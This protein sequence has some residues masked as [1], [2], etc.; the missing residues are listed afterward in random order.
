MRFDI[1]TIFPHIFA[2]YFNE[3]ILKR[4]QKKKKIKI[5][6]WDIRK[7]TRDKHHTVDDRPYGGGPGMV[8]KIEPIVHCLKKISAQRRIRLLGGKKLKK[9]KIILFTPRGKQ[10]NQEMLRRWSKLSQLIFVCGHYEGIDERVTKFVDEEISVGPYILTSGELPTMIVVDAIT[11]L[12]PGVLGGEL[13]TEEEIN[14]KK[15]YLAYPQYT[16][17]EEFLKMKVPPVL[18]TGNHAK[19]RAW[20]KKHSQIIALDK[21]LASS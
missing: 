14:L 16:R 2:S 4:A 1:L 15:G 11:R 10:L 21:K 7:Y 12:I 8:L 13:K 6:I 5:K 3:S 17:P 18:L 9:H 19:I 20:R